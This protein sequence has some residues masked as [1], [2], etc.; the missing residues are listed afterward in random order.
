MNYIV[1][2]LLL[3][4]KDEE[5]TF[6]CF[7]SLMEYYL[8]GLFTKEFKRLKLLFYQYNRLLHICLPNLVKHFKVMIFYTRINFLKERK[9]RSK[10]FCCIMVLNIIH[11]CI[12]IYII[13]SYFNEDMGYLSIGKTFLK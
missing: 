11:K 7:L 4:F 1:G 3:N 12:L 6:K 5:L 10:L 2:F 9:S 8:E 13:F